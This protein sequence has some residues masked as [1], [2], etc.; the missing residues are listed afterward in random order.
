MP[1]QPSIMDVHTVTHVRAI[2]GYAPDRASLLLA[3][4]RATTRRRSFA[5]E[6]KPRAPTHQ[7]C[8]RGPL[9]HSD[10]LPV[11]T[12]VTRSENGASPSS[13]PSACTITRT[14]PRSATKRFSFTA[15]FSVVTTARPPAR[16][17]IDVR[18]RFAVDVVVREG[19]R[20]AGRAQRVLHLA[21]EG[22]RARYRGHGQHGRG[23]RCGGVPVQVPPPPGEEGDDAHEQV[24]VL[25][26]D[27][28]R[29]STRPPLLPAVRRVTTTPCALDERGRRLPEGPAWQHVAGEAVL[30]GHEDDVDLPRQRPVLE[31]VVEHRRG[32][33]ARAGARRAA[34]TRSE[35]ATTGTSG[36]H[37]PCRRSSSSP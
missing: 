23:G 35:S 37:R 20:S 11:A 6:R 18:V 13:H 28:V 16:A 34:A 21:L 33:P 5:D 8:S 3:V 36:F 27:P 4:A 22:V 1:P 30:G 7:R 12:E 32:R 24:R 29:A 25:G 17:R 9:H 2:G 19:H 14:G 15:S 10:R 26:A 31:S